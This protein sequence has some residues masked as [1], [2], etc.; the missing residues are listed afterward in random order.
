M[1][2]QRPPA[3][4]RRFP[5][6]GDPQVTMDFNT[7]LWSTDWDDLGYL[8]DLGNL[9]VK[10]CPI[11]AWV[12]CS[13][14]RADPMILG[15]CGWH[16]TRKN[17]IWGSEIP[18]HN[19]NIEIL[20]MKPTSIIMKR[21]WT[22]QKPLRNVGQWKQGKQVKKSP[23]YLHWVSSPKATPGVH[24]GAPTKGGNCRGIDLMMFESIWTNQ[25][26]NNEKGG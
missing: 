9:R 13:L 2:G 14:S 3:E 23:S 12:I 10:S 25:E 24:P 20:F 26:P 15:I 4:I 19:R 18:W 8:H 11:S 1:T 7:K 21:T 6:M 16:Q 22:C 17:S 5:K